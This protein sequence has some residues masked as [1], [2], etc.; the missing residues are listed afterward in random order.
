MREYRQR[1]PHPVLHHPFRL[2]TV[3]SLKQHLSVIH[4]GQRQHGSR[5]RPFHEV[6]ALV[7]EK[8]HIRRIN[9]MVGIHHAWTGAISQI[10]AFVAK[11]RIV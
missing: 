3:L 5:N 7:T 11:L 1:Q 6:K 2:Q 10:V 9:R 4:G 8:D